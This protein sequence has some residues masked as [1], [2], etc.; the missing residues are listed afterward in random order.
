MKSEDENNIWIDS[1]DPHWEQA[2]GIIIE[3]AKHHVQSQLQALKEEVERLKSYP[4]V[5][6]SYSGEAQMVDKAAVKELITNLE[7]NG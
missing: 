6:D 1:M 5:Y 3:I 7:D 4:M 2:K